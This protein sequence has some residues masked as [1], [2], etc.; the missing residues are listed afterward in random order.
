[1]TLPPTNAVRRPC[2]QID[3]PADTTIPAKRG[4]H[5]LK[6]AKWRSIAQRVSTH[7]FVAAMRTIVDGEFV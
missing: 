3:F 1:M 6:G 4:D 5:M 2:D 7:D